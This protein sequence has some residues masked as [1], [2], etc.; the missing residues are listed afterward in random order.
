MKAW[1]RAAER[2]EGWGDSAQM[3]IAQATLFG[4][5]LAI[6]VRYLSVEW[7]EL[8]SSLIAPQTIPN[9]DIPTTVPHST[10]IAL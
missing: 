2:W 9:R 4:M 8:F 1:L 10:C 3:F 5:S 6:L 7:E